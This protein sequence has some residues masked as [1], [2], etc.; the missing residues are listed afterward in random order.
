MGRARARASQIYCVVRGLFSG[1]ITEE[2]QVQRPRSV[3]FNIFSFLII[4]LKNF[5]IIWNFYFFVFLFPRGVRGELE[6]EKHL[7]LNISLT[8]QN[9]NYFLQ[10]F[11][12]TP[13][14]TPCRF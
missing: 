8:H 14:L 7:I 3:F 1:V 13:N 11:L 6:K 9:H 5:I 10:Y 4:L 2:N 12:Y